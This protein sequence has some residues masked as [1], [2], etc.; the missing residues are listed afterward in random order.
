MIAALKDGID[1]R[2]RSHC[3]GCQLGNKPAP[4]PHREQEHE[5]T[6]WGECHDWNYFDRVVITGKL[7]SGNNDEEDERSL[8][9]WQLCKANSGRFK[10]KLGRIRHQDRKVR[11][12]ETKFIGSNLSTLLLRRNS[13]SHL[14]VTRFWMQYRLL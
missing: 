2:K 10:Y 9:G 4:G 7:L 12:E 13:R 11:D 1:G 6:V 3:S 8:L 14:T 5:R